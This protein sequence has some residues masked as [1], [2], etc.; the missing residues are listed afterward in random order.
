MSYLSQPT[1]KTDY[2]VVKVG[3]FINVDDSG[4]ISSPEVVA[5]PGV[6]VD[7]STSFITISATGA[8]LIA[9][10]GVTTSYTATADDEYIGVSSAAAVT[11][12]LPDAAEGRVYTIK[13]EFGQGSGKITIQPQVGTLIDKKVNYIISVPHQSIN[14]VY[15][16]GGW[17]IM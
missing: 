17:W 8:D 1:S 5:G 16:A 4:V 13:D 15:R 11:I 2:G 7:Y 14:V 3:N 9:V 10:R 6:T 12:T